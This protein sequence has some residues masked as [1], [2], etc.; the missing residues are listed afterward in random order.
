MVRMTDLTDRGRQVL[1]FERLWY[2]QPGAKEA[3]IRELFGCSATVYFQA[4]NRLLDEPAALV[5]A[6][7]VV[8]RLRRLRDE[9]REA[10][11]AS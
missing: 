7:Q 2:R 1:D 11:R 10:R 3:A 8:A 6:P 4:L 9:R 5:Y